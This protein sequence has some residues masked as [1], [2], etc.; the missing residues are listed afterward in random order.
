MWNLQIITCFTNMFLFNL[1]VKP[2]Y[3]SHF[4]GM[5]RVCVCFKLS[6]LTGESIQTKTQNFRYQIIVSLFDI[7][8]LWMGRP[9]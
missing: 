2:A 3:Y 6:L 7:M 1:P 9:G 8:L 4:I 5:S